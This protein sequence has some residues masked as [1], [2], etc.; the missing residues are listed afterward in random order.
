MCYYFL[1]VIWNG[2]EETLKLQH[3]LYQKMTE[4]GWYTVSNV[5]TKTI[6]DTVKKLKKKN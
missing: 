3:R 2:L 6:K 5:D 4:C 1:R